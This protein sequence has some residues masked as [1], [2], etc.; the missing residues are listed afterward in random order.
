MLEIKRYGLQVPYAR[1]GF[2]VKIARGLEPSVVPRKMLA[3]D[4]PSLMVPT[5]EQLG[6]VYQNTP[7]SSARTF[8]MPAYA[9]RFAPEPTKAVGAWAR[10]GPATRTAT[11]NAAHAP[12]P[13]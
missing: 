4:V 8:E 2:E 13:L 10:A 5:P 7:G 11:T 12:S 1:D 3:G 6:G 9:T